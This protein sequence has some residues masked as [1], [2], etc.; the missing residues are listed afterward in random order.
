M[1]PHALVLSSLAGTTSFI[2][3]PAG[4]QAERPG[5]CVDVELAHLT[6]SARLFTGHSSK[7]N[8][9]WVSR[10]ATAARYLHTRWSGPLGCES[11]ETKGN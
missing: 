1:Q 6:G 8:P 4:F 5:F 2:P 3:S 7:N 9:V 10:P 11:E